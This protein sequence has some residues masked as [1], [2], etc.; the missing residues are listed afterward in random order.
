MSGTF[1]DRVGQGLYVCLNRDDTQTCVVMRGG[2]GIVE[3]RFI[4]SGATIWVSPALGV[5]VDAAERLAEDIIGWG[6]RLRTLIQQ[7]RSGAKERKKALTPTP[8]N[9]LH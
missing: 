7:E 9:D 8:G 6:E 3:L 1:Q 2:S 5:G 4:V